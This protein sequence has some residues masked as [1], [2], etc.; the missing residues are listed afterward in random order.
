MQTAKIHLD[1]DLDALVRFCQSRHIVALGFYG[2]VLAEELEPDEE[3][4]VAID[5]DPQN[6]PGWEFATDPITSRKS[7][8][9]PRTSRRSAGCATRPAATRTARSPT[10]N[11]STGPRI[12]MAK[13]EPREPAE[14]LID[15]LY[16]AREAV[17]ATRMR[18]RFALDGDELYAA[19]MERLLITVG[20]A[21]YQLPK[22]F[23]DR[24]PEVPWQQVKRTRHVL[25]HNFYD[26]N[27]DIVWDI[28]TIHLPA[29]IPQVTRV[30]DE[31]GE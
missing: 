30:L 9:A 28:L 25:V 15:L 10:S 20:E 27:A 19:A 1:I 16:S 5:Y 8:V 11:T 23:T 4:G 13:R 7:S 6:M 24:Y 21:A 17:A 12:L 3:V 22:T 18:T 31:P 14:L 26:V 29:L 2:P